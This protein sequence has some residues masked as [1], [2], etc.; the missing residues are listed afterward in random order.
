MMPL[1]NW[2]DADQVLACDACLTG[3]GGV[4]FNEYFHCQFPEE[5][6]ESKWHISVLELMVVMAC[7]KLWGRKLAGLKIKILC[8][9]QAA[10]QVL[11]SGR[12]KDPGLQSCLREIAFWTARYQF[13]IWPVHIGTLD[14]RAP[15]LLSRWDQGQSYR[16]QF[17][18][19]FGQLGWVEVPMPAHLFQ[20]SINW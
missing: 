10:T 11:A 6:R 13:E 17:Q 12:S 7:V 4:C 3:A 15:D 18:K 9:N 19:E 8:D 1:Q 5:V 2:S 20:F 16:E 14:N